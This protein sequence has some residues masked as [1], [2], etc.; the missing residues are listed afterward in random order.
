MTNKNAVTV[1]E[2]AQTLP[3]AIPDEV[4]TALDKWAEIGVQ[5]QAI[6]GIRRA[7]VQGAVTY[8]LTQLLT[9]Q[10]M[11]NIM[12]LQ[13]NPMGFCT[14]Q[15]AGYNMD[16]VRFCVIQAATQGLQVVGNE[17]NILA[18]RMYVTK[19][20]MKRM[21]RKI[22]GL[23]YHATAGIPKF[24]ESG[25]VVA[26]T[27]EWTYNGEKNSKTLEFSIRVNKGMGAD[28]VIGKATRKAL[29]WLYEEVTGNAADEGEAADMAD[30]ITVGSEAPRKAQNQSADN[31]DLM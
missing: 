16:T 27:N 17:F 9:P 30:V 28:A 7:F 26:M 29:A 3:L 25:A 31:F 2:S 14:D 5:S 24:N 6:A 18:G 1:P 20:G 8:N 4:V 12:W 11:E 13:N 10:A 21:L 15:P 22:P 23:R 19:N